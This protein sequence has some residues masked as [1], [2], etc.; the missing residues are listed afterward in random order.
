M[1]YVTDKEMADWIR[2][3]A[4]DGA[5]VAGIVEAVE[6]QVDQFCGRARG[7]FSPTATAT[8]RKFT[9]D[10]SNVL[11]VDDICS[12]TDLAVKTDE[13]ADGTFETTLSASDYQT[14]PLNA[15][16]L[17]RSI[18]RLRIRSTSS[19]YWPM[20]GGDA[21]VEVTAC[22]GWPRVPERV[23]TAVLL[24]ASRLFKRREA[25]FGVIATPDMGGGE[26][27]LA[28]LDP[29]VEQL[30]IPLQRNRGGILI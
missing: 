22:W 5:F 28:R 9:A 27:L 10:D 18:E 4:D 21:L 20:S 14:E 13:D 23:H 29:D 7:A 16:S 1:P 3:H 30:L 6:E 17:G 15:L 24:Q 19:R 25:P 26:R 11:R 8:A 2:S 12:L